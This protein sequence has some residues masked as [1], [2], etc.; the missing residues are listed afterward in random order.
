MQCRRRNRALLVARFTAQ[1]RT[2]DSKV[3]RNLRSMNLLFTSHG[4]QPLPTQHRVGWVSVHGTRETIVRVDLPAQQLLGSAWTHVV[5]ATNDLGEANA[6][7][8]NVQQRTV[9]Y[10]VLL[11]PL[12]RLV[13]FDLSCA[14]GCALPF[15]S[16]QR[17]SLSQFAGFAVRYSQV[18]RMPANVCLSAHRSFAASEAVLG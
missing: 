5:R 8:M 3:R 4:G 14:I 11:R 18:S 15:R 7:A 17:P 1:I 16:L 6:K 2:N 9:L 12:P 13:T 10:C